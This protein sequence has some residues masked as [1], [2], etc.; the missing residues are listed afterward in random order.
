MNEDF[1]DL[2]SAL[3]AEQAR[4]LVVGADLAALGAS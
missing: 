2:L 4:F 3:L 1:T